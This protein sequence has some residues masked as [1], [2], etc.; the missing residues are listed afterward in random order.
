MTKNQGEMND[1]ATAVATMNGIIRNVLVS[2]CRKSIS[3]IIVSAP[4]TK[5]LLFT[6][7]IAE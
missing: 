7:S 6:R 1:A 2:G 3:T 5:M 4:P